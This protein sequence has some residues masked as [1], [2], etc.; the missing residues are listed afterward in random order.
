MEVSV[1]LF[2]NIGTAITRWTTTWYEY[3][4]QPTNS[5][6]TDACDRRCNSQSQFTLRTHSRLSLDYNAYQVPTIKAQSTN[7]LSQMLV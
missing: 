4:V 2:T 3:Q 7:A 6:V 5:F 1:V